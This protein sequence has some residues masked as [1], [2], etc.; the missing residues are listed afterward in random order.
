MQ[1]T[2]HFI[3]F[4][5]C[6]YSFHSIA[7]LSY[8][9]EIDSMLLEIV[10]SNN[11]PG[12]IISIVKDGKLNY[13]GQ[14]GLANLEYDIPLNDST[15]FGVASITKQFTS[16]CIGVLEYQGKISIEDD[17][18]TYIPEL[19]FYE[20]TIRIKHLL[21]HTSGIRNHNILLDLM[22]FDLKH[23]GYTNE[24]IQQMM[25][26][27]KGVNGKPGERMLYSNTN[28]VFLALIIERI[29][30]MTLPDFAE[31]ELFKPLG[32][33]HTFYRR[34][35]RNIVKNR[36]YS[37]YQE[38]G[39]YQ[40]H[41]SLTLCIGAGGLASTAEDLGTWSQLFL[42]DK[43]PFNYLKSFL[44][45]RTNE[46]HAVARGVFVSPY[47]NMI[48]INHG[49]R[50]YGMRSQFI[51]VPDLDLSVTVFANTNSINAEEISYQI[52]DLFLPK[53][54][55]TEQKNPETYSPKKKEM[56]A[57][58]G[59]YREL[60]SDLLMHITI[61]HD[62]IKAKS[63]FGRTAVPLIPIEKGAFCRKDNPSVIYTFNKERI[64]GSD[65]QVDFGG[66]MFYFERINFSPNLLFN[67]D[68]Y[69]GDY[70]SE[71][72][73]INYRI[74]LANEKLLLSYLN[75]PNIVLNA[76]QKDIFGT[77]RRMKLTFQRNEKN[78]IESFHVSAEGTVK[79]I[80]F[81]RIP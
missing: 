3:S 47:R 61:D 16:A 18:R 39:K 81:K 22:G 34:N 2:V 36:S 77:G 60:N 33:Q 45:C 6:L 24:S 19:R 50:D 12:V 59:V 75:N 70:Y 49:G 67:A 43:H 25:F 48:T 32:M 73:D 35:L 46:N 66:G 7:Q 26:R 23:R 51:C 76:Q 20:D 80:T 63:S 69:T 56:K 28:Y 9:D 4:L 14:R 15:V 72:L 21:D 53:A 31:K 5:L 64:A 42:D 41:K 8:R 65:M 44:T 52:I 1:K 40:Q 38:Q 55:Q 54:I 10:P 71:E 17:V 11:E 78:E 27:Q 74:D 68:D 13:H 29:S 58:V 37:Y 62:S 57:I 30:G 79:G